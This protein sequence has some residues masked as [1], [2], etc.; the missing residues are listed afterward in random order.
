MSASIRCAHC[1]LVQF[2]T[3]DGRCRRCRQPHSGPAEDATHLAVFSE[4]ATV[5][6]NDPQLDSMRPPAAL[7]NVVG[8][9]SLPP[10]ARASSPPRTPSMPP[11]GAAVSVTHADR[12]E[13]D[14]WRRRTF[15]I[16]GVGVG[17]VV[18]TGLAAFGYRAATR[19]LDVE[20]ARVSE[21]VE[22]LSRDGRLSMTA[23]ATFVDET[24]R[25][26]A[27]READLVLHDASAP[28]RIVVMN[29]EKRAIG[30]VVILSQLA[31]ALR[32]ASIGVRDMT[33][34]RSTDARFAGHAAVEF[35][36]DGVDD[37]RVDISGIVTIVDG[38]GFY[39]LVIA[40]STRSRFA[41]REARIRDILAT[42]RLHLR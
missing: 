22:H 27:E 25:N 28:T 17:L 40:Y 13:E 32:Q 5:S 21:Q 36:F 41:R 18:F 26:P 19:Y 38:D 39:H 29:V 37:S 30:A 20:A 34:G 24:G 14:P 6:A 2:E 11:V 8:L 42:S 3:T 15:A 23:P 16:V 12:A 4:A 35:P 7:P 9:A 33:L 1:K 31:N 10:A